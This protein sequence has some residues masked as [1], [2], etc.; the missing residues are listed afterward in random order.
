MALISSFVS[1]VGSCSCCARERKCS[2]STF[3]LF[4]G[5]IVSRKIQEDCAV[6]VLRVEMASGEGA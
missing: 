4:V 2:T 1:G 5:A 3:F 6:I